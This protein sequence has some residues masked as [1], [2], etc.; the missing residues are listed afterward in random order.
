MFRRRNLLSHFLMH[1]DWAGLLPHLLMYDD[2]GVLT[3]IRT[4]IM[5]LIMPPVTPGHAQ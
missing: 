5:M 1:D 4:G 3:M 2:W